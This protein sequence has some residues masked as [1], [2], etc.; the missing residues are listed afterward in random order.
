VKS[1]DDGNGR[2]TLT[3]PFG[4]PL[5]AEEQKASLHDREIAFHDAW[6]KSTAAD[7]RAVKACFEAPTALENR[8]ILRQMGPLEGKRILDIGCGL[9]ESSVY[10]ALQGASVTATDISPEMVNTAVDLGKTYGV[11][12]EGIVSSG[13]DLNVPPETYDIVYVANTIHHVADRAALFE[14]IRGALKHGGRFFSIDPVAYNPAIQVYRAMATQVR[15]PD[16]SPLRV[17]DLRLVKKYFANVQHREFWFLTLALFFKYYLIDRVH[18][19]QD[20]YWKR[21]LRETPETIRW[22]KPLRACDSFLTR[23]PILRWLCWNI[24][25]WGEKR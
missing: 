15:T 6:A 14:Q 23:L 9:G 17:A 10:F 25:I 7:S 11:E 1:G 20:R 3:A 13:E 2:P 19:N 18:P 21:I 22:W 24:V 8:F 5:S 16:E 4:V 12:L